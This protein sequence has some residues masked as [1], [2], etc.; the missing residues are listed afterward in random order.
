LISPSVAVSMAKVPSMPNVVASARPAQAASSPPEPDFVPAW[1]RS[2]IWYQIFPERFCNGDPKNDPTTESL[3][4]ADFDAPTAVWQV[5]PWTSDWYQL[6]P[7]EQAN[8]RGFWSNVFRRRY[9]GDLQGIIDRLDYLQHLGVTALYLTPVFES[10]SLHKYDGTTYHH[11][12]PNFGPDPQG[13]RS[14]IAGEIPDDP[15]TW[16]WTRADRLMLEL[17]RRVHERD[18]KIIFD[19]VFNHM[20][21]NNW[22]FQDVVKHQQASRYRNWFK[23]T[24]WDDASMGTTFAYQGWY[25]HA[26]LPE[27]QQDDD[28]IVAEP[29]DYIF[30]AT[31]RWMAPDG[32]VEHGIDGWR[33]DVASQVRH[34]FWKRWRAL[35][36]SINPQAYLTGEIIDEIAVVRPFLQGD[37]FDA[38]MNY[39]FAFACHDF[40]FGEP[41]TCTVTELDRQLAELRAA[42]PACVA[43]V[44]Q[45]LFGSH[46]TARVASHSVNGGRLTYRRFQDYAQDQARGGSPGFE[47]RAPNAE[48]RRRQRLFVLFQMTYLGA[49]MIYYGDEAGMWGA[50]DPCC[51]K[52]M[53]WPE[54]TY[55]DEVFLPDGSQRA[56][57][58]TVRFDHDVFAHYRELI[59]LRRGLP[60]LNDGSY[61]TLEIDD[62]RRVLGFAREISEQVVIVVLNA[63]EVTQL[64][65]VAG[66]QAGNWRHAVADLPSGVAVGNPVLVGTDGALEFVLAPLSGLVAVASTS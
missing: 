46:D 34:G 56:A 53:L 62:S 23:V 18:M 41:A 61:R 22:A 1:A 14:M 60:A 24:S 51:R 42:F 28:G 44:M 45:N 38:V 54:L 5:H 13:D 58:H 39:Q 35:V 33:L 57:P 50:T 8:G 47:V 66:P 15:S 52:P 49:P 4:G 36:K 65:R 29:R 63:S 27:L 16:V 40:F 10:P 9:G 3:A 26:S 59:A 11:I 30:A 12:D 32:R 21:V 6:A 25:G 17:I 43:P 55:D 19:G 20:G 2:A 37:E 31:R 48:E 64:V 7:Y